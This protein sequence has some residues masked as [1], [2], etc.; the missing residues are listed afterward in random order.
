MP[1]CGTS[2][3]ILPKSAV[4]L[5]LGMFGGCISRCS[6]SLRAPISDC[7]WSA[8]S[9]NPPRDSIVIS[10]SVS[11]V[12]SL[13]TL[14]SSNSSPFEGSYVSVPLI[15]DLPPGLSGTRR[16]GLFTIIMIDPCE[17]GHNRRAFFRPLGFCRS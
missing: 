16:S 9:P 3:T 8:L 5:M 7:I 10:A 14:K 13:M 17:L 11:A 2:S 12:A 6:S 1:H 15:V 4:A